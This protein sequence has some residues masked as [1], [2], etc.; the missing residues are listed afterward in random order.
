MS[1]REYIVGL[2]KGVDYDQFNQ[3]MIASTGEGAIPNRTVDVADAR[4]GSY[5]LTHYSLT[6][7]E[8]EA[9]MND[10]RVAC[11]EIP[12]DQRDDISIGLNAYQVGNFEKTTS[13]TG[14]YLNWGLMRSNQDYNNYGTGS[15]PAEQSYDYV[16]DGEG[17]DIVIQDSGIEPNHPEWEDKDGNSRLQQIDWA[18]ASGLPF[19][20]N[21]NHYRD[22]DGH[23]THV[24]GIA[25]GKTYGWA[26]GAN[27]YAMKVAGLEGTGDSGTGISVTYCFDA[28]KLWHRNKGNNRPTVVNMSWGYGTSILERDFDL[29][30]FN[31]QPTANYRGTNYQYGI[32]A[33]SRANWWA[34]TGFVQSLFYSSTYNTLYGNGFYI[35]VPGRVTSVDI[36]VQEMIDEGIH[37]CIAAGNTPFKADLSTGPDYN[38][39]TEFPAGTTL[40]SAGTRLYYHRGSSPFS[41]NAFM[42]GNVDSTPYNSSEDKLVTSSTRGPA[43]NICA[44]GDNIMSACSNTNSKNGQSYYLDSNFKQVNI[45]GTSMASPQVAGLVALYAQLNPDYTP[46]QMQDQ[47]FKHASPTLVQL[48]SDTDYDVSTLPRRLGTPNR[49]LRNKFNVKIDGVADGG[50]TLNACAVNQA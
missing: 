31:P 15:L 38:N 12:P 35:R 24:A 22:F 13:D 42:V 21:A 39:Y 47:I 45:G 34:L 49:M 3:D 27:I 16:L 26:K 48:G 30:N 46:A 33:S 9:L 37:V 11:V 6:D 28:I 43:I 2:H 36:D 23:G 4:P 5:R 8:A 7:A 18:T 19:T 40:Y 25:A 14:T 1:E 50:I 41:D 44:P 32:N 20:Q 10:S 17:V 29:N